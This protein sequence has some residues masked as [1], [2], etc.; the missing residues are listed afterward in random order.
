[1]PYSVSVPMIRRTLMPCY[2][3]R[4]YGIS[5]PAHTREPSADI[6]PS[7]PGRTGPAHSGPTC[8]CSVAGLQ[9]LTGVGHGVDGPAGLGTVLAGHQGPDVDDP[10]PLLARDPRPVVGVGGVGQ[11][12]VLAE[13]VDARGQQVGDA[14]ALLPGLQELLDGHLLRAGHDVLDHRPGV[15]VLEVQDLLVPVRVGDLEEPVLLGLAVHP[16]DDALAPPPPR[17]LGRVSVLGQ[18]VGVQRHP[19]TTYLEKMS[20]AASASGRSILIL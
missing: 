2:P 11:V 7:C 9:V 1:M 14:D 18:V 19:P 10:L 4:S 16:L 12:L 17:R 6:P 5:R 15:E 3:L 8:L 20:F 13:L